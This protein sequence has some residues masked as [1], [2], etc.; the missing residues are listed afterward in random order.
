MDLQ[1]VHGSVVCKCQQLTGLLSSTGLV[2]H[3][4]APHQGPEQ[5]H[6]VDV[7]VP[8]SSPPEEAEAGID[9][10]PGGRTDHTEREQQYQTK[11]RPASPWTKRRKKWNSS[12]KC[13]SEFPSLI[14]LF[15][16]FFGF[17]DGLMVWGSIEQGHVKG[18]VFS[19]IQWNTNFS[20]TKPPSPRLP[21][22]MTGTRQHVKAVNQL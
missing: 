4:P 10:R 12:E 8:A 19:F 21:G 18:I 14:Y 7:H 17:L 22:S 13:L 1:I 15:F 16:F 11:Y 20:K 6:D 9:Q 2:G 3:S 5:L